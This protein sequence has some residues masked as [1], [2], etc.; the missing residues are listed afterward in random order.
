MALY[1]FIFIF[2]IRFFDQYNS[3]AFIYLPL[4]QEHDIHCTDGVG[5]NKKFTINI[6]KIHFAIQTKIDSRNK[7]AISVKPGWSNYVN[8]AIWEAERYKCAWV[9]KRARP[10]ALTNDVVLDGRCKE[11]GAAIKGRYDI[12]Q[13]TLCVEVQGYRMNHQHKAKRRINNYERE[14]MKE[15]LKSDSANFVRTQLAKQLMKDERKL[16]HLPNLAVLRK[17]KF[18]TKKELKHNKYIAIPIL[19]NGHTSRLSKI[20]TIHTC[21]FDALFS[22]YAAAFADNANL[23]DMKQSNG[24][25]T[26]LIRNFLESRVVEAAIYNERNDLIY[27]LYNVPMYKGAITNAKKFTVVNCVTGIGQIHARIIKENQ[28]ICSFFENRSCS[29]CKCET[30]QSMPSIQLRDCPNLRNLD[31]NINWDDSLLECDYCKNTPSI[32]RTFAKMVAVEVEPFDDIK[33]MCLINEISQT[34]RL[35]NSTYTLYGVLEYQSESGKPIGHFVAHAKRSAS[36]ECFNDQFNLP[37]HSS[38]HELMEPFMLF[39]VKK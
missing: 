32:K 15:M 7:K 27:L 33:N 11:C 10:R 16:P 25:F 8:N 1:Y 18:E 37:I 28:S 34:I 20:K 29:H 14:D 13:K 31:C 5:D 4:F 22:I 35:G 24:P 36:W 19:K 2:H 3:N 12:Q 38:L 9:F 30:V 23:N 21:G 6:P 26:A 39:Y 17:I